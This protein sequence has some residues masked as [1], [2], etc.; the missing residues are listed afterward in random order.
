MEIEQEWAAG[1]EEWERAY[2]ENLQLRLHLKEINESTAR[3]SSRLSNDSASRADL[4]Q[5][6]NLQRQLHIREQR[7]ESVQVDVNQLL[8]YVR[9]RG[10]FCVNDLQDL[11]AS[12]EISGGG[13]YGPIRGSI[14][15]S[16][17]R[18]ISSEGPENTLDFD[19]SDDSDSLL[20]YTSR[21]SSNR[22]S[23]LRL[24]DS[25]LD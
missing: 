25:D 14:T 9:G 10:D 3:L 15:E 13:Q 5:S 18:T 16:L 1:D 4:S 2:Q 22:E 23:R 7:V 8:Q 12:L 24:S 21:S 17:T 19:E 20:S 11:I 6:V